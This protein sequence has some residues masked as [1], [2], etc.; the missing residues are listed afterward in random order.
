MLAKMCLATFWAIF[1][2]THLVTLIEMISSV[3]GTNQLPVV[4]SQPSN[5]GILIANRASLV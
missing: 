2:Q 1:L 4:L 5:F 3:I